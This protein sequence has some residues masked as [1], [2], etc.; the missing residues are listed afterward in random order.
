MLDCNLTAKFRT[1]FNQDP[2]VPNSCWLVQT[3]EQNDEQNDHAKK[4]HGNNN[5]VNSNGE[6]VQEDDRENIVAAVGIIGVARRH[7][8]PSWKG[9]GVEETGE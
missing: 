3:A 4:T 9:G 7:H 8:D 6:E 2:K 1:S 5:S